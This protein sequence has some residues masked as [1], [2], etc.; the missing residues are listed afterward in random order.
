MGGKAVLQNAHAYVKLPAIDPE[1]ARQF[2]LER[3]GFTPEWEYQGH[4]WLNHADGSSILLFPSSG[5]PS[6]DHDQCGWVVDDVEAEVASLRSRGIVFEEF[7]GR[8]FVG[9]IAVD[10]PF[11]AAWFRDS[12]GNLLNVRGKGSVAHRPE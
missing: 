11:K 12:E 6:G 3:L 1:R 4:V 8:R 9:G 2:Y 7:P 10:G 5:K